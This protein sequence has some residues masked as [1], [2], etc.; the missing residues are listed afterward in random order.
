MPNDQDHR[1]RDG[2]AQHGTERYRGIRCLPWFGFSFARCRWVLEL[3]LTEIKLQF[4]GRRELDDGG[5][6]LP[7][8]AAKIM[9]WANS[10]SRNQFLQL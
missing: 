6:T 3:A 7:A 8:L 10:S 4:E 5:E 9:E 1:R 2:D